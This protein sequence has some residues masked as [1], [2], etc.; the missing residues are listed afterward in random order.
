M[1]FESTVT[2]IAK[3]ATSVTAIVPAASI[4]F[5]ELPQGVTA[6]FIVFNRISTDPQNTLDEGAPGTRAQI[7]NIQIQA[8]CYGRG[9]AES[10]AI[11]AALRFALT[12]N[13]TIRAMMTGQEESGEEDT[14]LR[15]QILTFSCWYAAD[16]AAP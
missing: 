1:S 7:D 4:W 5:N 10:L 3:A 14:R 13:A 8:A 15:G 2:T 12:N 9:A 16:I 6:P 11:A